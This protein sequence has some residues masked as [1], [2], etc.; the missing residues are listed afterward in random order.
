[1]TV[2]EAMKAKVAGDIAAR[3][4]SNRWLVTQSANMK[5]SPSFHLLTPRGGSYRSDIHKQWNR[6][7]EITHN[8]VGFPSTIIFDLG[9]FSCFL[10][11]YLCVAA[12]YLKV[13]IQFYSRSCSQYIIFNRRR[14]MTNLKSIKLMMQRA[15]YKHI[16]R[17]NS[18]Y[19]ATFVSEKSPLWK[20]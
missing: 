18:Q 15:G 7:E 20:A 19:I 11:P 3:N 2:S 14:A 10:S 4:A 16:T 9:D 12:E 8:A 6:L 17:A 1:M 13:V 5:K